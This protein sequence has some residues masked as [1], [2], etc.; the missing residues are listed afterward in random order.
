MGGAAVPRVCASSDLANPDE[1]RAITGRSRW[2]TRAICASIADALVLLKQIK[3]RPAGSQLL[4]LAAA[5]A[6][7]TRAKRRRAEG[8]VN[9]GKRPLPIS[10]RATDERVCGSHRSRRLNRIPTVTH[11]RRL[12][13]QPV[14][15]RRGAA[16]ET[17]KR[18]SMRPARCL[19]RA[20]TGRAHLGWRMRGVVA[21]PP[22][23]RPSS[24]SPLL[25]HCSSRRKS[26]SGHCGRSPGTRPHHWSGLEQGAGRLR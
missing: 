9:P 8:T 2:G 16:V 20:A 6:R 19:A 26:T 25:D 21:A 14:L 22:C 10:S 3:V 18:P 7:V 23:G 11:R 1:Q 13:A 4:S 12:T 15:R 24:R 5:G 17:A